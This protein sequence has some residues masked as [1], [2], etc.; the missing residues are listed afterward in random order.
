MIRQRILFYTNTDLL[1][2]LFTCLW[3]VDVSASRWQQPFYT[4]FIGSLVLSPLVY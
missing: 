1:Y 3:K 4:S 2:T